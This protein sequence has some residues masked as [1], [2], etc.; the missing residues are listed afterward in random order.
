MSAFFNLLPPFLPPE[1]PVLCTDRDLALLKVLSEDYS[2]FPHLLCIWHINKNTLARCARLFSKVHW[3]E[4]DTLC[5]KI[6]ASPTEADYQERL[7]ALTAWSGNDSKRQ[8]AQEYFSQVWLVHKEKFVQAWT[9]QHRHLGNAATSRVEGAH[10]F[11]KT[12][13]GSSTGDYL[14]VFSLIANGLEAQIA[15]IQLEIAEDLIKIPNYASGSFYAGLRC[16]ISRHAMLLI[17]HE[18]SRLRQ[19]LLSNNPP[20]AQ[21]T[22]NFTG[23]MGLPCAHRLQVLKLAGQALSLAEVFLFWHINEAPD[24]FTYRPL[25]EPALPNP[26]QRRR[27]MHSAMQ[28]PEHRDPVGFERAQAQL[29]ATPLPGLNA[30]VPQTSLAQNRQRRPPTCSKCHV[31]GHNRAQ[32][33]QNRGI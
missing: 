32:C 31:A 22:N 19:S 17:S 10:S 3:E 14:S 2:D 13:I 7:Q 12:Y 28:P 5:R 4:F 25:F 24:L 8:E 20:L 27:I 9:R 23:S 29:I 30:A 11:M 15:K 26:T 33:P 1:L 18:D 21:C 6:T 16:N